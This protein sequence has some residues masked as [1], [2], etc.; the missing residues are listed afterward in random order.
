MDSFFFLSGFLG[1]LALIK[2][3]RKP[4]RP[5]TLPFLYLHRWL[6]LTPL[7][8]VIIFTFSE[9]QLFLGDGP[10]FY[11]QEKHSLAGKSHL[12]TTH[13]NSVNNRVVN[14]LGDAQDNCHGYWWTNILYINNFIPSVDN[15]HYACV[16]VCPLKW[17]LTM[18]NLLG[19]GAGTWLMICNFSFLLLPL[20]GYHHHH[21]DELTVDTSCML[22][23]VK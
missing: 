12:A 15:I 3:F 13:H 8:I 4:V 10:L 18:I 1:A 20:Y 7:Y 11:G 22:D 9:L 21:H 14:F 5:L 23:I 2:V 19:S 6:R 16:F 17:R